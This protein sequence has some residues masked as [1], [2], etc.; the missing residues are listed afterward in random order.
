MLLLERIGT[1]VTPKPSSTKHREPPRACGKEMGEITLLRNAAVAIEGDTILEVGSSAMLEE[2]YPTAERIDCSGKTLLP[3]FVDSHT[4]LVFAGNRSNEF[5][6]RLRGAT[7]QEIYE[8]GGGIRSTMRS[9]REASLEEIVEK[10]RPLVQSAFAHGTTTIEV[11]SGYGLDTESEIKLLE[12]I[13]VLNREEEPTLVSTFLGAHAFP[14]EFANDRA[15][16]VRL[17]IEEMIP[18][19]AQRGL[20]EYCDVFTDEGY[21]TVE[22]TEQIF[23]AAKE[24][25]MKVRVHADELADVSAASMASRVKAVSADHLLMISEEGIA[26]MKEGGVIATLLPGTAFYLNL[27]YAPARKLI[28][29]GLP[30]ALATDCNPG[31]NMCE[32]MGMTLALACM[33]MRMTIEE[34][35]TAA[36]LNGAAA[37]DRSDQIGQIAPG[38]KADLTL[39]AVPDYPDI[40]YH[41]GVNQVEMVVKN[42]KV[43][44]NR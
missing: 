26:D 7:Y 18:E 29:A 22:E 28:E 16:Y 14:P 34:S 12:A 5:A 21:F 6:M 42:G 24:H 20:A 41:Y 39:F 17:V 4:H 11:K 44:V 30:V 15:G 13:R 2:K 32:N 43:A 33:G 9:V 35:I 25:G 37:L 36:T 10:C 1:L 31:T 19:V 23:A 3:G 40:V 38:M 8:A 27:P